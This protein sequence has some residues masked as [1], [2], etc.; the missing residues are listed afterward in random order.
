MKTF[1][2]RVESIRYF[3]R[4]TGETETEKVYGEG[5]LRWVYGNPLG[6]LSLHALVK[7]AAF[8]KWYGK[9]M[10]TPESAARVDPF[11]EKYGLDPADFAEPPSSFR[12]FNEFF[13]RK[14]KPEARPIADS[15][16]V[17][18]ADGRHLGFP[19]I[20]AISSFFVKGQTFDLPALLGDPELAQKYAKGSLVLSRLCPVDYH[21]YHFPAAGTP[22]ETKTLPGPLFSVSPIALAQNLAYLW[23]NKRT[24][25]HLETEDYGT[26]LIMEIGAT[27]VGSIHQTFVPGQ[28][29][30]KGAEKGYFAF[31]GSSTIT[32]FEPGTVTLAPDLLENSAKQTELY[33]R[34][35]SEMAS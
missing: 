19:D 18:P 30:A 33:A 15:P 24:L 9:R 23:T 16:I 28:P 10:S 11:I 7:R 27:C 32:I 31:G 14:L 22:S 8:S 13:Y 6:K 1:H 17:F 3:N 29:L 20:S 21:R 4:H 34:I 25:T 26:I 12:S 2:P 35:G 5:S